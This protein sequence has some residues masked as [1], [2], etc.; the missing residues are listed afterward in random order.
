MHMIYIVHVH[1]V[2]VPS[3]QRQYIHNVYTTLI[4]IHLHVYMYMYKFLK[5]YFNSD[6]PLYVQIF[7]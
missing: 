2:H 4:I 6:L 7:F 5:I 1:V 3:T